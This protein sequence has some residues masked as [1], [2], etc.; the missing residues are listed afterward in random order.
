MISRVMDPA[1]RGAMLPARANPQS[2][3]PPSLIRIFETEINAIEQLL[4][5][6]K[7]F[8]PENSIPHDMQ[9]ELNR[10]ALSLLLFSEENSILCPEFV[11][12]PASEEYLSAPLSHYWINSSHNTYLTGN[13]YNSRSSIECYVTAL[14]NGCRCVELDCWDGQDKEPDILHG[15]TFTSRIKLKDVVQAIAVHAFVSSDLPVI[16]SIENHCSVDQQDIMAHYFKSYFGDL[17]LTA[18]VERNEKILPSPC[19]CQQSGSL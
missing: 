9:Y 18:P 3:D 14:R 19:W 13:Q 4:D 7:R 8:Y 16:L 12:T 2:V 6:N 15:N 17:L 1:I 5:F 10:S 11:N